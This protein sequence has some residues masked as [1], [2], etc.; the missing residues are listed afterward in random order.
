[1]YRPSHFREDD[2]A[3]LAAFVDAH[4]LA[5]LVAATPAGLVANHI[6]LLRL[7][8]EAAPVRFRGHVAR[9][10]DLWKVLPAGHPVLAIFGGPHHYVSPAWY[11]TK[12]ESG[13]VVPTWNYVVAHAHGRIEFI[14]DREWLRGFVT[15][16]TERHESGRPAPWAV[17]DAPGKFIDRMLGAI[18]GFE[19]AI[20]RFEGKFKSSQNRNDRERAGVVGALEAEGQTPETVGLLVRR[21]R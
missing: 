3:A 16:L 15:Q 13:E 11:P 17:S 6:P 19:I 12:A 2:P 1:M 9:A 8:G 20:D 5:T 18:V 21:P 10:N 14:D 7:G 4:P